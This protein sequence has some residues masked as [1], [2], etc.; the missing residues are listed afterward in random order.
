MCK[1][2]NCIKSKKNNDNNVCVPWLNSL[3]KAYL[4]LTKVNVP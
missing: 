1:I 3:T 2:H 4:I